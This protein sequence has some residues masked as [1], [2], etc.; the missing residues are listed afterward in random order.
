MTRGKAKIRRSIR[1]EAYLLLLVFA[2]PALVAAFFPYEA[3]GFKSSHAFPRGAAGASCAF[4]T[5]DADAE[6]AALAA[7]SLMRNGSHE[8][9]RSMSLNLSAPN[10]PEEAPMPVSDVSHRSRPRIPEAGRMA[11]PPL[12]ATL[13]APAPGRIAAD[14]NVGAEARETF[15]REDMLKID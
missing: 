4:T 14:P 6:A 7:A 13:A 9:I 11:G 15:S 1:Q 10:L 5:L 12:P 3:I 8:R 2:L